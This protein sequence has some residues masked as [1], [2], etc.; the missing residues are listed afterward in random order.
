MA[1]T[2]STAPPDSA[3]ESGAWINLR[4]EGRDYRCRPAPGPG[5]DF[6]CVRN[7][8]RDP[9]AIV[10]EPDLRCS[11]Q[12]FGRYDCT[13]EDYYPS[14][15]E[16]YEVEEVEGDRVLCREGACWIWRSGTS[17]SLATR[18]SPDFVC[19]SSGCRDQG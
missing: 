4:H 13:S 1:P 10:G 7:V 16:G 6:D 15:I 14:E 17:A 19:D 2:A 11:V 8:G 3:P 9:E 18:G 5:D 12:A